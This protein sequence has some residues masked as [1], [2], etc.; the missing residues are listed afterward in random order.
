ML[1]TLK[2]ARVNFSTQKVVFRYY[3]LTQKLGTKRIVF[4]SRI[5]KKLIHG[6]CVWSYHQIAVI[7]LLKRDFP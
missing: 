4:G 6:F 3:I 7:S 5:N 2:G 1:Q